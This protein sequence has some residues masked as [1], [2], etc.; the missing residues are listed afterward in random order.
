MAEVVLP[1]NRDLVAQETGFWCGPA[2]AQMCLSNRGVHVDEAQLARECGTHNGGTDHLGLIAP[3]MN[4]YIHDAD[5]IV[6]QLPNDPP[7]DH[8]I[9]EFWNHLRTSVDAGFGLV[10]NFV[11]P[12]NNKPFPIKGSGPCPSFYNFGTTYHYVS[13]H[14]YSD[15]G[16]QRAVW[17]ADS[18]GAPFGYWL[19]LAQTVLIAA[20]KGYIY[21]RPLNAPGIPTLPGP[22]PAVTQH[23]RF[24]PVTADRIV[25]SPFGPRWGTIHTGVDFGFNGGAGNRPVFAVQSGTVIFS[26]AAAGYG[27]PDPCG[28]L[29]IDSD[30]DE[31]GGVYEYGHIVREASLTVGAKVHAGQQIGIINADE[32]SNGG[33]APHLHLSYMPHGYDPGA[34]VDPLPVLDGSQEPGGVVE[35]PAPPPPAPE[36]PGQH[37]RDSQ[38]SDRPRHHSEDDD[39]LGHILS[40]RAEGLL[41]QALVF[42]LA[43]RAGIDARELYDNVRGSF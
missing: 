26:G 2:S 15:E 13:A 32:G 6:V 16:G 7:T 40:L 1:Y 34:K 18:G 4:K 41:T 43:E 37:R 17:I 25:T 31:G 22:A 36:Q 28:W 14:G 24:W 30:T 21:A 3:V 38:L 27:G 33:V 11:A 35:Q 5:Y 9:E 29:V 12:A 10:V 8:E 23:G 42:A 39:A 20:G 19:T